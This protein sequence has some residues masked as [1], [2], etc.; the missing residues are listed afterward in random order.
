MREIPAE[1]KVMRERN[2]KIREDE[3]EDAERRAA[4][5]LKENPDAPGYFDIRTLRIFFR[6]EAYDQMKNYYL[7]NS[8]ITDRRVKGRMV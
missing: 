1:L 3:E 7:N 8:E 6:K 4:K 5:Y 2:R